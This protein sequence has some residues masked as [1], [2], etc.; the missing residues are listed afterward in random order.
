MEKLYFKVTNR[1]ECHYGFQYQDGLNVLTEPFIEDEIESPNGFHFTDIENILIYLDFGCYLREIR[2]PT[3]DQ[4]FKIVQ[5][6][7]HIW[8]ANKI[9]LGKRRELSD[10]NTFNYLLNVGLDIEY[11]VLEVSWAAANGYLDIVKLFVENGSGCI[12]KEIAIMGAA[13]SGHF[14]IVKYLMENVNTSDLINDLLA[15]AASSGHL[16]MVEFLVENGANIHYRNE[17]ALRNAVRKGHTDI[18]DYLIKMGANLDIDKDH[19][20]SLIELAASN[21]RLSMI[22]YL[23]QLGL[24]IHIDND[25]SLYESSRGGHFNVVCFLVDAGANVCAKDSRPM[26][27]AAANGH[28]DIVKY[29]VQ[30]GANIHAKN[31]WAIKVAAKNGHLDTVRYF[32][33]QQQVDVCTNNNYSVKSAAI[34]GH[35]ELVKYLVGKGADINE[36]LFDTLHW[37]I[38]NGH[39]QVLQYIMEQSDIDINK[40]HVMQIA[41]EDGHLDIV[42]FFIELGT[43]SH[44]AL[45]LAAKNGRL[46]IVQYFV[47]LGANIR[48]DNDWA[49]ITAASEGHLNVV[50]YLIKLGADIHAQ[51]DY[52]VQLAAKNGHLDVVQYVVNNGAN[53]NININCNCSLTP[54]EQAASRG[55]LDIVRYLIKSGAKTGVNNYALKIATENNHMDVVKYLTN[56]NNPFHVLCDRLANFNPTM[57]CFIPEDIFQNE[58]D[59]I[60]N[61]AEYKTCKETNRDSS[62]AQEYYDSREEF[63]YV[64]IIDQESTRKKNSVNKE[65]KDMFKIRNKRPKIL[66]KKRETG[67]PSFKGAVCKTSK[68]KEMLTSIAKKIN[69]EISDSM[70]RTD[71]C[72]IIRDKLYHME[73]YATSKDNNKLTYLIIPT[74]HPNKIYTFPLCLEDRIKMIL[75]DIQRETCTSINPIIN[76]FKFNGR[77]DD[78]NYQ[79]YEIQFDKDMNKFSDLLIKYGGI[80]DK[81]DKW[82]IV[83]E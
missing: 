3:D 14:E 60:Q 62:L 47:S 49:L 74:N 51:T 42:K 45:Q 28:L 69:L 15:N 32:I 59:Y 9:I 73:K 79:K 18:V 31:D 36:D 11:S 21:G 54:L 1:E 77:F 26:W 48:A 67:V 16:P 6:G 61:L 23:V 35:F 68:D 53:I 24:D 13:S 30:T 64:G 55:H 39:L 52:S 22:K 75:D 44:S 46:N 37:V 4:E 72:D 82:T 40:K 70:I 57:I 78:I 17:Y 65:N 25:I 27:I 76:V 29:L 20:P 56:I 8:R 34:N 50:K 58:N 81:N 2:L 71:I 41:I 66:S 12:S 19:N 83:V 43:D 63:E 5:A 33:E 38:R 10:I 80:N 7:E